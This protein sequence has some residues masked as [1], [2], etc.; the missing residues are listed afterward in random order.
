M[1][2]VHPAQIRINA[3]KETGGFQVVLKNSLSYSFVYFCRT[4]VL[5]VMQFPHQNS[6][7]IQNI[8]KGSCFV[9]I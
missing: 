5:S 6:D 8:I 3:E 4:K 9:Q 7:I 1:K 2:L